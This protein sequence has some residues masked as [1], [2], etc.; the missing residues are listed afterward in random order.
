MVTPCGFESHLSHQ[1]R[2]TTH[3]ARWCSRL[4]RQPVTLE[5][6]G[7]SPFRVAKKEVIPNGD[8]FFFT[9][10]GFKNQIGYPDVIWLT[11]SL[12]VVTHLF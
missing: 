2:L 7:S 3:L 11:T 9:F 6:D 10:I 5:V 4:A 8:D 12:T 1:G